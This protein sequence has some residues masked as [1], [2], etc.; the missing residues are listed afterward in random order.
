MF[1]TLEGVDG[2]GKTSQLKYIEDFLKSLGK[3]YI[4]TREPGGTPIGEKIRAILLDPE[5]KDIDYMT[6]LLLYT[7]DRRQHIKTKIL[8]A[9]KK[10]TIVISDRFFDATLAYKGYARG[11]NKNLIKELHKIINQGLKPDITFLLDVDPKISIKRIQPILDVDFTIKKN[12]SSIEWSQSDSNFRKNSE[13][14]FEREKI[15]F[16]K[17]VIKGYLEIAKKEPERFCIIDASKDID[18][19]KNQ[20]IDFL[21]KKISKS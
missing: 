4:I 7:A 10:G 18:S 19:V 20:I 3:E 2:W 1:I 12:Q 16:R 14:K 21:S 13:T 11:L 9:I 17:R 8:P 6:E 15:T 5:N